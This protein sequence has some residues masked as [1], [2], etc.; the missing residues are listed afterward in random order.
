M[1]AP[2]RRDMREELERG[3]AG[4]M[5]VPVALDDL[6]RTRE[7][8]VAEI[9]SGIPDSQG[10]AAVHR[11]RGI[12]MVPTGSARRRHSSRGG[13]ADEEARTA[14]R[15]GAVCDDPAG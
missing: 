8:L 13:M 10:V 5:E 3:L 15:E 11:E 14:R 1:L 7:E 4:M 12:E 9:V 2:T 6:V